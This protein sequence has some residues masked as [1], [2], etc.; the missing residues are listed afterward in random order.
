[1]KVLWLAVTVNAA[2]VGSPDVLTVTVIV[3]VAV[4]PSEAVPV[5]VA[6][7]V[8]AGAVILTVSPL[9][10]TAHALLEV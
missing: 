3:T 1:M 8:A 9:T 6:V 2:G 10:T 5:M 7:S 4:R